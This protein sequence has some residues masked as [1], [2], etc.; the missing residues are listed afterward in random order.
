[1]ENSPILNSP[2]C[3]PRWHYA[4]DLQGNL[5]YE[6]IRKD[7]RVFDPNFWGTPDANFWEHIAAKTLE[8]LPEVQAYFKNA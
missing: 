5:N 6:D 3:E 4:T 2:Y 1:M 7:R 8:E